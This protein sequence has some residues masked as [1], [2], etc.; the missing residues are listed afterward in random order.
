MENTCVCCG[1]V[2]P[3]GSQVCSICISRATYTKRNCPECG[4]PLEVYYDGPNSS[5]HE[6]FLIR[7]CEKCLCDW[8]SDWYDDGNESE[9]RR[10]FWG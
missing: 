9:L 10:K 3:E 2:I 5:H 6:P 7:H 1:R 4:K 8:E